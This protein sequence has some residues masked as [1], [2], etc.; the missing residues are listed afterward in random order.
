MT[1]GVLI[2]GDIIEF[3]R[4]NHCSV[5]TSIDGLTEEQ[6]DEIRGKGNFN[7]TV[8]TVKRL[9]ESGINTTVHFVVHKSNYPA[10]IDQLESFFNLLQRLGV[11]GVTFSL[12]VP[13]GRG[14]SMKE[15]VLI[16]NE[17]K[18]LF[19]WLIE[20]SKSFPALH[21]DNSR[22]L[23]VGIENCAGGVCP[24]GFR[25]CAILP[26]GDVLPCRRLPI[27]LGNLKS[28]SF[29][30]IWYKSDILW[31]LRERKK[32]NHCGKCKFLERC[33]GCRAMAYAVYGDFMARDP[34]C[35][36]CNGEANTISKTQMENFDSD[37]NRRK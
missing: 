20:V 37:H 16:P 25:I 18:V 3:L 30:E 11:K 23:W 27:V 12:L 35:F 14:R 1:N 36:V 22:P 6:H 33:A 19:Q 15:L 2:S 24:A 8:S 17:V 26:N 9:S 5:Q 21:L 4:D 32:I 34:L 13:I 10:N 29:F 31:Q 7:R 28:Q